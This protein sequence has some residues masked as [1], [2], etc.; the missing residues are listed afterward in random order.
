MVVVA[1]QS[2]CAQVKSALTQWLG[3]GAAIGNNWALLCLWNAA[4]AQRPHANTSVGCHDDYSGN[5]QTS[6]NKCPHFQFN[7]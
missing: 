1:A 6:F 3:D 2:P 7:W 4:P 5:H